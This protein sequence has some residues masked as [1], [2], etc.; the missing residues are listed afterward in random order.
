MTAPA[1]RCILTM[2]L[3]RFVVAACAP[4]LAAA[5]PAQGAGAPSASGERAPPAPAFEIERLSWTGAVPA[6]ARLVIVNPWGDVRIKQTGS[7]EARVHAVMQK[8]GTQPYVAR[9]DVS[10][11]DGAL[12]AAIVY[13]DDRMPASVRQ[14]RVDVAVLVPYGVA[15]T[16]EA[17]RGRV[18][19]RGFESPLAVRA[20]RQPVQVVTASAVDIETR[21]ADVEL[22]LRRGKVNERGRVRTLGGDIEVRYAP[23]AAVAFAIISGASRTSNDAALL[24]SRRR[25]GRRL[26]L[27][28][29]DDPMRLDVTSDT[30]H[31]L[32]VNSGGEL[33][34]GGSNA[35]PR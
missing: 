3:F 23:D 30:G 17:D 32:L 35:Q 15:T 12:R 18:L 5:C 10:K 22:H 34:L 26:L 13:P 8:I 2:P 21:E 28:K 11:A 6:G 19:V 24:A 7:G 29:G 33:E 9:L 14:G 16:V 25:D 27:S 20:T 1:D 4:F 31:V